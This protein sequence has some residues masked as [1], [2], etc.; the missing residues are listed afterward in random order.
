MDN[1]LNLPKDANTNSADDVTAFYDE[2]YAAPLS[3]P[4]NDVDAVV[5]FF[6]A[7]KFDRSAAVAVASILL[8]QAKLDG[9]KVF[10]ILDTLKGLNELQLSSV[11]TE[12]MNAN[13]DRVS[14]IGFKVPNTIEQI[15]SRNIIF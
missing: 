9:V 13:R 1:K 14:T 2:Y 15:E 7:R 11:V 3:Y 5:G 4:S 8:K 12:V 6:E 10:E